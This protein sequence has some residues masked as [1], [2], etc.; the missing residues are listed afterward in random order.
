VNPNEEEVA[1]CV[2]LWSFSEH[3]LQ[4]SCDSLSCDNLVHKRAWNLWKFTQKFWNYEVPS[5][6]NFLVNTLNKN[7]TYY[8][9]P[10][11]SL[12]IT[13]ICSPIFEHSTPLSYSEG[14]DNIL[15]VNHW[16]FITHSVAT[17]TNTRWP[18]MW[19]FT[20]QWVMWHYLTCPSSSC[21]FI[22]CL[23]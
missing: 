6:T 7:I 2:H 4:K 17:R 22:S 20:R 23:K 13:N 14:T 21:S 12:F 8:R 9:W 3:I 15:A 19:W 11:T 10:T 16:S 1:F 5:F 18:V